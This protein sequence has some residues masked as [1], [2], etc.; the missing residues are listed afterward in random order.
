MRV[1]VKTGATARPSTGFV[2]VTPTV[3]P[4]A[5]RVWGLGHGRA[6]VVTRVPAS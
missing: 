3:P 2:S 6:D 5:S 4:V 1:T